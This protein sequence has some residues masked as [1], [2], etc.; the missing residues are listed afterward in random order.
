[1][2]CHRVTHL[3]LERP[4]QICSP[5]SF[6]RPGPYRSLA[7]GFAAFPGDIPRHTC[8]FCGNWGESWLGHMR[9]MKSWCPRPK[10]ESR[11]SVPSSIPYSQA[12]WLKRPILVIDTQVR[13]NWHNRA[14]SDPRAAPAAASAR[15]AMKGWRPSGSGGGGGQQWRPRAPRPQQSHQQTYQ[16]SYQ[17]QNAYQQYHRQEPRAA[18]YLH[19]ALNDAAG[20]QQAFGHHEQ[21]RAARAEQKSMISL[22]KKTAA[23][24]VGAMMGLSKKESQA[25]DREEEQKR[26]FK[27]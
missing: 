20:M 4:P 27:N 11:I 17:N 9:S 3:E 19:D 23:N 1:M 8:A 7:K 21:E 18:A 2:R 12:F 25:Y 26:Y 22:M 24:A 6:S 5:R 14:A 16:N 13:L 15:G 10:A